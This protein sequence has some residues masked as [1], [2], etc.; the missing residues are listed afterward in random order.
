MTVVSPCYDPIINWV[1][2]A[3]L[4]PAIHHLLMRIDA[5]VEARA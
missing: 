1:V 2:I 3:G 5:R 4:D